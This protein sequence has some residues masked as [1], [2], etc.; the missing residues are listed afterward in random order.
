MRVVGDYHMHTKKSDGRATS[1]EMIRAAIAKSLK[2][3][4]ITDHGPNNIGTGVKN[5]RV[6][7]ET[8]K[9]LARLQQ[10]FPDIKLLVG[11]EADIISVDGQIDI[12]KEVIKE[13]DVL[14]VGFHPYIWPA[15]LQDAWSL[16][17]KNLVAKK[18]PRFGRGLKEQNTRTLLNTLERYPVDI[19]SHP[20][21]AFPINVGEVAKACAEKGVLFEINTG[22]AYITLE[23]VKEAAS[24]GVNFIINS[25]AHFPESVGK[26]DFGINIL[27]QAQVPV[28]RIVNVEL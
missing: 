4:A 21:L 11:A 16:V 23:D 20:N 15:S 8:K 2:T 24:Q 25:D 5:E 22:H 28:E 7:L 3:I 9:E 14:I 6:F 13:L 26:A 18:Y 19:V 17:A 27:K 10:D 1:L 12:S